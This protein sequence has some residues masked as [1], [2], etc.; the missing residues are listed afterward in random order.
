MGCGATTLG[1]RVGPAMDSIPAFFRSLN[2]RR[3][4]NLVYV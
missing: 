1:I 2:I 4:R 3:G